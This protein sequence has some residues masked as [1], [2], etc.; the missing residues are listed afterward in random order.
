[1]NY[2]RITGLFGAAGAL[3]VGTEIAHAQEDLGASIANAVTSSVASIDTDGD[4]DASLRGG[5]ST[6]ST[7]T[8][9]GEEQ[10]LAIADASGGNNNLSFVS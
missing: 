8:N 10:G 2:R 1:M 3:A 5:V 4:G 6:E 7:E 9:L